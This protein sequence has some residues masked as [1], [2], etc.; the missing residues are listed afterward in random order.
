MLRIVDGLLKEA[1][2]LENARREAETTNV[3]PESLTTAV[4]DTK[5]DLVA[6]TVTTASDVGPLVVVNAPKVTN[7]LDVIE[8]LQVNETEVVAEPEQVK[9]EPRIDYKYEKQ[10]IDV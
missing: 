4:S 10:G 1:I 5:A 9:Q 3:V 8:T 2:Q 6:A 7:T